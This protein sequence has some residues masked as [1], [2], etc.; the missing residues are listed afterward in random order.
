M[1]TDCR[2]TESRQISGGE[3]EAVKAEEAP[4]IECPTNVTAEQQAVAMNATAGP[5]IQAPEAAVEGKEVP[6]S[7]T[8]E[9]ARGIHLPRKNVNAIETIGP[10]TRRF[11]L[12]LLDISGHPYEEWIDDDQSEPFVVRVGSA[13]LTCIFVY[14]D[15]KS[16]P[17]L[18][19]LLDGFGRDPSGEHHALRRKCD[20]IDTALKRARREM[21]AKGFAEMRRSDAYTHEVVEYSVFLP[22]TALAHEQTKGGTAWRKGG[23]GGRMLV[24][25]AGQDLPNGQSWWRHVADSKSTDTKQE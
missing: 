22:I 6:S 9:A 23:G 16:D 13:I 2:S 24:D 8:S 12:L 17:E 25:D 14:E 10:F 19:R 11:Y 18:K 15:A 7:P 5:S 4:N 1:T 3:A 21:A 20:A